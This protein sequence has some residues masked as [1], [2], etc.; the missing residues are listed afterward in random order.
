MFIPQYIPLL[1]R[2]DMCIYLGDVDGAVT[3]HFLDVADVNVGFEEAGR[4]GV[5]E[6]VRCDVEVDGCEGA[7]FVNHAADGLVGER[8]AGLIHKKVCGGG[9]FGG[10]TAAV[11]GEGVD[12]IIGCELEVAFF[13]TF[14]VD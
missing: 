6:H 2:G 13:V 11:F 1:C 5:A 7:V 4:E 3:E 14:A 12:N 8:G 10:K 9:G